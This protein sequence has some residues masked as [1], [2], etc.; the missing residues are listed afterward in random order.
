MRIQVTMRVYSLAVV[1]IN[2]TIHQS[3]W[4]SSA[5]MASELAAYLNHEPEALDTADIE[6]VQKAADDAGLHFAVSVDVLDYDSRP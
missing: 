2:G 1:D 4:S 6:A 3:V 5:E